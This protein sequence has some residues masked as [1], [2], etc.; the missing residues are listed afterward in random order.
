[1]CTV[2]T[3]APLSVNDLGAYHMRDLH[4]GMS[5]DKGV[6]EPDAGINA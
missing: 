3:D 1:M 5:L 6:H 4:G 2:L